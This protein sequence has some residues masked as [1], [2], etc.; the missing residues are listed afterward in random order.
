M[1]VWTKIVTHFEQKLFTNVQLFVFVIYKICFTVQGGQAHFKAKTEPLK[2]LV[3]NT[4]LS[5]QHV[6]SYRQLGRMVQ[7]QLHEAQRS[8]SYRWTTKHGCCWKEALQCSEV[9]DHLKKGCEKANQTTL[10]ISPP[11]FPWIIRCERI[12]PAA[13]IYTTQFVSNFVSIVNFWVMIGHAGFDLW[14]L[15]EISFQF[16]EFLSRSW[17]NG[18]DVQLKK[19]INLA[20]ATSA[21]I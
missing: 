10:A 19:I 11:K 20:K 9:L 15:K 18:T 17:K 7:W 14:Q 6:L 16:K 8:K 5:R 21:E 12:N 4:R 3:I 13:Q 1:S 2:L